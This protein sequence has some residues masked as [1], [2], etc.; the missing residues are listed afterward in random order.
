MMVKVPFWDMYLP[1]YV[2]GTVT[3]VND[4][5]HFVVLLADNC[6]VREHPVLRLWDCAV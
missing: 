6:N 2:D 3:D 5:V 4:L 1:M